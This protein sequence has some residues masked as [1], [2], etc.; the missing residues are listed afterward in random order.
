M[1]QYIVGSKS[2]R[3]GDFSISS[4]PSRHSTYNEA[5]KEAQRLANLYTDKIFIPM[6]MDT[7]IIRQDVVRVE[8]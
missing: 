6:K 2:K 8:I 3:N 1:K 4:R 7:G 5:L